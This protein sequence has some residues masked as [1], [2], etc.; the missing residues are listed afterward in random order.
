M[1]QTELLRRMFDAAVAAAQ[2]GICVPAH[3]PPPPKGRTI[4]VGA[5]KASAAMARALEQNWSGDL[6][7][8]VVTRYGHGVP[9]DRIEI[10][11]AAHPVPDAAGANAAKRILEKVSGLTA[12]DL[13][14]AL[15]SGGGSSLLTLPA[16]GLTLADK[17]AVNTALLQSGVPIDA[18][19]CV[20][21]H[22]SAIKGGRLARAA[23]PARLETLVISDVPGD[24]P[25]IIAS[26]PTVPDPTHFA[27]ARTLIE[28]YGITL[29]EVVRAHLEAAADESPK[30]DDPCFANTAIH[31]IAAPALALTAAAEIARDAGYHLDML[32]DTIEGEAR[33]VAVEHAAR[34]RT[35][36]P[37]T[38]ILSGG[39]LTV[40]LKDSG[41]GGPNGEYALALALALEGTPGIHA[42][43][44]DTDG[45]DGSEDNA[46]AHIGPDTLQRA[47]TAGADPEAALRA[48]DSYGV[49]AA[50]G[51]LVITGP[52]HTNVND[53]RAVL[54]E[55]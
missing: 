52:T 20:R 50:L 32:G 5:G 26:G 7:G 13:V 40:T 11:E 53:F 46:G 27:D 33:D 17:Q 45:I 47:A 4:V 54:I 35:A 14:I 2:P 48:N 36:T 12:D 16:P 43:A 24:D 3:L 1:S 8:L 29:P 31:I 6:D 42:M 34:A 10:V 30:P 9:C 38:I 23:A 21:K 41:R 51:D 49:F 44:C 18:M 19:N 55:R 25:A 28:K 37:G 39:E 15:I 22:L